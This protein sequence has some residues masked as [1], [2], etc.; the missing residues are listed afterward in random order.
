MFKVVVTVCV[1]DM[2][3][4][5]SCMIISHKEIGAVISPKFVMGFLLESG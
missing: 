1:R 5:N 2:V 4:C 3:L